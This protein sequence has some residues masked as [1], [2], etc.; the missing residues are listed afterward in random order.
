MLEAEQERWLTLQANLGLAPNTLVAYRRAVEEYTTFCAGRQLEARTATREHVALYVR[1]LAVRPVAA[2]VRSGSADRPP[3]LANATILQ[4][5]TAIRLYYDFLV[6]EGLR[7]DNPV[8]RGWYTSGKGFAGERGR[9]LVPRYRTLPWIPNDA[10]WRAVLE[11]A[12][13]EPLRKRPILP[14]ADDPRP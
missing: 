10:E 5:L 13:A 7:P 6:E 4:R 8:S 11:A 3:G 9:G 12:K 2:K 1:D 14:P